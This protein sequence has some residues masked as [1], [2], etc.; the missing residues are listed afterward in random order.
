MTDQGRLTPDSKT[1]DIMAN[2][3]HDRAQMWSLCA[4]I[5]DRPTADFVTDLREDKL[6]NPVREW[7]AWLGDDFEAKD[8]IGALSAFAR[9][10][11]RFTPEEDL[12]ELTV[13]WEKWIEDPDIATFVR[14]SAEQA[15][16]EEEAWTNR[17][18]EE[19]KRLRASQFAEID[20]K[21]QPLV[22]WSENADA[23]TSSLVV[24]VLVRIVAAHITAESGRN[25]L[26]RLER[27]R[28]HLQFKFD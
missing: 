8:V 11:T 15:R 27:Q 28:G 20:E 18:V 26:G 4:R 1:M 7:T 2:T 14:R 6:A 21:F 23:G 22:A 24:Q 25:L 5:L 12:A 13:E 17:E 16:A 10:S 19:A 3:A 9:R